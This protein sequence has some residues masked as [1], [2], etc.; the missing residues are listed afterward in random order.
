MNLNGTLR[1]KNQKLIN[2]DGDILVPFSIESP[3]SRVQKSIK[4]G[5]TLFYNR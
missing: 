2:Y 4:P 5:M 3:L 1:D